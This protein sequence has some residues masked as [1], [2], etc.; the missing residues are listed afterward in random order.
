MH[1]LFETPAGFALFKVRNE[2]KLKKLDRVDE[3]LDD[4]D[5][6]GK[7]YFLPLS[8]GPSH[9]LPLSYCLLSLWVRLPGSM[10]CLLSLLASI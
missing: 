6:I 7:M 1:L 5:Q 8:K 2:K 3:L 9:H 4:P 10:P